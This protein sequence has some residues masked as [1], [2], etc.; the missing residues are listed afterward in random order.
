MFRFTDGL[1]FQWSSSGV[2]GYG[3][4]SSNSGSFSILRFNA[5]GKQSIIIFPVC[6]ALVIV[7]IT[8]L[9]IGTCRSANLCPVSFACILPTSLSVRSASVAPS[10]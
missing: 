5:F 10:R 7:D 6:C 8:I 3:I 2:N 9:S 4:P 1:G